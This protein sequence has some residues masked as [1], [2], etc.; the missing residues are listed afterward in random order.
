MAA[1]GGMMER[2]RSWGGVY[3]GGVFFLFWGGKLNHKKVTKI[4]YKEGLRWLPFDIL[5]CNNQPKTHGHDGGGM[6]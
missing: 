5:S 1:I 6:G 4:K 2:I 3:G